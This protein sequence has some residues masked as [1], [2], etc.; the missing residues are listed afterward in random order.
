MSID[1]VIR[2]KGFFKKDLPLK[3]ILGNNLSYGAF[4]GLRLET[5]VMK[6]SEFI[7]Y[8]SSHIGRG[9]SVNYDRS[10]PNEITLRLLN[11]TSNEELHD[12]YQCIGRIVD[13]WKCDLEVDGEQTTPSDFQKG[14]PW[15]RKCN[16]RYLLDMAE[17]ICSGK[18]GN[19]TLF[20]AFWPLAVGKP[21]AELFKVEGVDAF[22]DWM[23]KKQSIDA[24]YA[25]PRFFLLNRSAI[26]RYVITENTLSIFP[27]KGCVPFG[28][29]D[30]KTNEPLKCEI[31]EMWFY[32]TSEKMMLGGVPYEKF[33]ESIHHGKIS[34]YDAEHV[35]VKPI[36]YAEMNRILTAF[37]K[38]SA[39]SEGEEDD[40]G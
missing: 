39:H 9:F 34:R 21:E 36:P 6:G 12:F 19:L 8:N 11:P 31:Y 3:T 40:K 18:S 33:F 26:G 17:E 16:A 7:A 28:V 27:L 37:S 29:V 14:L 30:P 38:E 35:L 23:H 10:K 32:S 2:Q 22:R 1:V 25:K 4:D 20:S 24:Y 15:V 5:G 13:H